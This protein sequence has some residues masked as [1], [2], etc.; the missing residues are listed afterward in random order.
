MIV[1]RINDALN[2]TEGS[3]LKGWELEF[4]LLTTPIKS[5]GW[6]MLLCSLP[7]KKTSENSLITCWFATPVTLQHDNRTLQN[8]SVSFFNGLLSFAKWMSLRVDKKASLLAWSV[9]TAVEL[10]MRCWTAIFSGA[11]N[12]TF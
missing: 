2:L 4:D 6:I 11:E 9:K 3:F 10:L 8:S 5:A 1:A 12:S 7:K